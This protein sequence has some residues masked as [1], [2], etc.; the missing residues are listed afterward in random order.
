MKDITATVTPAIVA[1]M[2]PN[3]TP[4]RNIE[5]HLPRVLAALREDGI[6]D[7]DM[8]TMALATIAAE[9][10]GF[11]PISEGVSRFNT[12]P[13]GAHFALYDHRA[14]LG[15]SAYGHGALYKG[16][17]FIQ[18]T[19]R[20]NYDR[21]GREIGVD[22]LHHP[23]LANDPVIAARILARFLKDHEARIRAAIAAEDGEAARR[24]VNGGTHG[25]DAFLDAW[26]RGQEVLPG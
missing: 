13:G 2:F 17:G 8:V 12:A 14:D 15:N 1:L 7:I 4:R 22:L 5:A 20:A 24:A 10:A 9:T 26:N 21:I 3:T 11:A 6:G 16:R 23:D 25:I 19:G 18:I